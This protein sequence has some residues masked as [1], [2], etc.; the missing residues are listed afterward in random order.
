MSEDV[1][2][3]QIWN[4][5]GGFVANHPVKRNPPKHL[6]SKECQAKSLTYA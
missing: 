3:T 2:T 1:A 6:F 5:Q 4:L